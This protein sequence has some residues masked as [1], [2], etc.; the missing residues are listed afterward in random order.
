M[1]TCWSGSGRAPRPV[2]SWSTSATDGSLDGSDVRLDVDLTPSDNWDCTW[3]RVGIRLDL[4]RDVAHVRWFGTGPAESYPDSR[5]AARV[6]RFSASI[7]D[8]NVR[9]LAARR[10]P[11]T[12]RRYERSKSPTAPGSGCTLPRSLM[13]MATGPASPS[14]VTHHRRW[15]ELDIHTNW[16]EASG[17]TSS[18]TMRSMAWAHGRAVSMCCPNMRCGRVRVDSRWS[19]AGLTVSRRRKRRRSG[20]RRAP[21]PRPGSCD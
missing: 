18:S 10:K 5:Q 11:D 6:G 14:A 17:P 15:T 8:L 4:P 12:E 19:F 21:S 7:D 2:L 13:L 20:R 1:N 16:A 9:L 3:P